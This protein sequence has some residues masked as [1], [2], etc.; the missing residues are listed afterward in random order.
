VSEIRYTVP[1]ISCSHC[2]AAISGEVRKV[3]G[4]TDVAVDIDTKLVTVR[5]QQ[6]DEAALRAAIDEAGYDAAS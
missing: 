6:L 3:A 5:G 4:V 1:D 2:V